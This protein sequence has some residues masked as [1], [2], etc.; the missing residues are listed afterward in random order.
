MRREIAAHSLERSQIIVLDA[1][2]KLRQVCCD[3]RLVN[4]AAM[5]KGLSRSRGEAEAAPAVTS[6]KLTALMQMLRELASE[7][8]RVLVFSQF[9]SMLDLI[10]RTCCS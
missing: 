1:L 5:R 6:G 3:P 7:G 10:T 9:T 4:L 2:L 8:R